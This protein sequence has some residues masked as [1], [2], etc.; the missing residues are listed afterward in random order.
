M[1]Q[2]IFIFKIILLGSAL[3]RIV[4]LSD[5]SDSIPS[6]HRGSQSTVIPAPEDLP[7]SLCPPEAQETQVLHRHT[8]SETPIYTK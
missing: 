2:R 7:H 1:F 5:D 3:E 4:T 6:I 8:Y